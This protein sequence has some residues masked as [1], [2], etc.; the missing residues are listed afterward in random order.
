[1]MGTLLLQGVFSAAC[2]Q[3]YARTAGSLLSR[4]ETRNRRGNALTCKKCFSKR[5]L[6]TV[7]LLLAGAR[8]RSKRAGVV[9]TRAKPSATEIRTQARVDNARQDRKGLRASIWERA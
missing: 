7:D 4:C 6:Q 3:R 9:G 5:A 2:L 8:S 1:M